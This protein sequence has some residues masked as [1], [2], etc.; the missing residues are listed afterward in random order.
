MG[1]AGTNGEG[2]VISLRFVRNQLSGEIPPELG[3]L[4]S[5]ESLYLL[6]G[7]QLSGCVPAA[8][9]NQVFIEHLT[10]FGGLPFCD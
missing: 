9:R 5:L 2:H 7:N 3:N 1:S 10:D 8:L 6:E 4:A